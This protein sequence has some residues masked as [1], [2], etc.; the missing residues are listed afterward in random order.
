MYHPCNPDAA[1]RETKDCA[2]SENRFANRTLLPDVSSQSH[3]NYPAR[4]SISDYLPA[5]KI[6][7][8]EKAE[9]DR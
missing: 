9:N 5:F 1:Y 2:E 8:T 7:K 3:R 6:Q 4:I